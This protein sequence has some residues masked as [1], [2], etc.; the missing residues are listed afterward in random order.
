MG[1]EGHDG[2]PECV[3]HPTAFPFLK[4]T[5]NTVQLNKICLQATCEALA[6]DFSRGCLLNERVKNLQGNHCESLGKARR[7]GGQ[8]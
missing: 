8:N 5:K 3:P 2:E 1:G 7:R 6:C 4:Y